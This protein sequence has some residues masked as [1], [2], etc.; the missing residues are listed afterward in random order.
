[1]YILF[2]TNVQ[3]GQICDS[4]VNEI[5]KRLEKGNRMTSNIAKLVFS[6]P[7]FLKYKRQSSNQSQA[8]KQL[9]FINSTFRKDK[10][11]YQNQRID[12]DSNFRATGIF[13]S[14]NDQ[15][16]VVIG[17]KDLIII[18]NRTGAKVHKQYLP[19]RK[20]QA[21]GA[22]ESSKNDPSPER[23]DEEADIDD[24]V[25]QKSQGSNADGQEYD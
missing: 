5:V 20:R 14:N 19:N 18:D 25:S 21:Q 6:H 13:F 4:E 8:Q 7:D 15:Y 10:R 16:L 9:K 24:D 22:D 11:A 2:K 12:L 1:M 3:G 23:Y 17:E